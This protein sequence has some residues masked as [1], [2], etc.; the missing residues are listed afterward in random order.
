MKTS[1]IA[2][3]VLALA[4]SCASLTGKNT[5]SGENLSAAGPTVM[6]ARAN[7]GTV[8]LNDNLQ[9]RQRAEVLADVKDFSS[10]V[11]DVKLRFTH[12]PIELSMDNVAGTT[13][14]AEISPDQLKQLAVSGST[15]KYEAQ[16]I[17]TNEKGQV[18]TSREP[19]TIQ[20]KAP[21]LAQAPTSSPSG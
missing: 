17:A 4:S 10:K 16:V 19:V 11:R 21:D 5:T 7:P 9:A 8:E 1:L 20:V 2:L 3:S 12:V 13:W 6:E 14:R 15:M 18:A